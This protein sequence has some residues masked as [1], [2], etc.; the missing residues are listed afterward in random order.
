MCLSNCLWAVRGPVLFTVS[1]PWGVG[2]PIPLNQVPWD[3]ALMRQSRKP[4]V[5]T[6]NGVDEHKETPNRRV[7]VHPKLGCLYTLT[8]R[9]RDP[10]SVR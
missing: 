10:V 5:L 3:A 1:T 4:F 7:R 6:E 2:G 9:F 8:K